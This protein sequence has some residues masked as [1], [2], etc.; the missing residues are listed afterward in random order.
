MWLVLFLI[1]YHLFTSVSGYVFQAGL[2]PRYQWTNNAGYCGEVSTIMAGLKHGQ[3]LS[4]Y[5]VRALSAVKSKNVQ[6]STQ[7]LVGVN[8]VNCAKNLRLNY[9]EYDGKTTNNY[10][11]WA[12]KMI[13]QGYAVTITVYMNHYLFYGMT[14]PD[15]GDSEYDHIVSVYQIESKYDD[16]EYHADD[17]LTLE[18]H[19]LWNPVTSG[20]VYL[21]NYTFAGFQGTRS[22]S[23]AK[24]GPIYTLPSTVPNYGI[25]HTGVT[26]TQGVLVPVTVSTS[27]NNEDPQIKKNSEVR[28]AASNLV[29][30]I[31]VSG[32]KSGVKYVMYWYSDESAVPT[33]NFNANSKN[34]SGVH[35]S[36]TF[37]ADSTGV[38]TVTES[39]LSSDKAIFRALRADQA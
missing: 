37:T 20:P 14:D 7:Y 10:L 19:G 35:K 38:H 36:Y 2:I 15:A 24:D 39:I 32:L 12:K 17:V 26:D 16:D 27:V 22:S 33:A 1:P 23:N 5:D 21:F 3:Y 30:T 28:P 9:I 13:R 4:Q 18:D 11:A 6:T 8:D 25:T 34:N 31:T 29:L